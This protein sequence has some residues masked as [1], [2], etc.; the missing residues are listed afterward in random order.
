L[1]KMIPATTLNLKTGNYLILTVFIF[2]DPDWA[3][4]EKL[5]E[6]TI[7]KLKYPSDQTLA[8]EY[9]KHIKGVYSYTLGVEEY[10]NLGYS[11][12]VE[13]SSNYQKLF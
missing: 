4:P 2:D 8:K 5:K 12:G 3:V 6:Y 13:K 11:D 7:A 9:V 1:S 10:G